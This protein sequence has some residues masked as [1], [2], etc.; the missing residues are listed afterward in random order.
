MYLYIRQA[1]YTVNL[2]LTWPETPMLLRQIDVAVGT[3]NIV[4]D[5]PTSPLV[6]A[7]YTA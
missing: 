3:V 6:S 7:T 2:R 1:L 4:F 5:S